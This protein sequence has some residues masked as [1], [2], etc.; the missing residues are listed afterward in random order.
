[1]W[2]YF[3]FS[4]VLFYLAIALHK[5]NKKKAEEAT[6][7][8]LSKIDWEKSIKP[9]TDSRS[10]NV[11]KH[12]PTTDYNKSNNQFFNDFIAFDLETTGLSATEDRILEIAAIKVHQ[13]KI[14][15]EFST[16]INPRIS[17]PLH[18]TKINGIDNSMVKTA[19]Y[20]EDILPSFIEFIE[21]Y[22]LIAH[23][24]SFDMKFICY[25]ASLYGFVISNPSV[26]SLSLCRKA[27]PECKNHKLKTIAS[28]IDYSGD[29]YHRALSDTKA[30]VHVYLKCCSLLDPKEKVQ[31][32]DLDAHKNIITILKAANRNIDYITVNP[33]SSYLSLKF[34]QR[35][36]INVKFQGKKTYVAV[37][38]DK[39]KLVVPDRYI[40]EEK[41]NETRIYLNNPSEIEDLKEIVLACYDSAYLIEQDYRKNYNKPLLSQE[42]NIS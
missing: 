21:D 35:Y 23:N 22:P 16:L 6:K 27:F 7:S 1:M 26:D 9:V 4:A 20:I 29:E 11:A 13:N 2:G 14:V 32:Y 40:V 25:N 18:I 30:L 39:G 38:I 31:K 41:Q 17:I 36:F 3:I 37:K 5:K 10:D 34:F 33:T 28:Y 19:Q 15:D 8:H 42:S 12:N 24:A